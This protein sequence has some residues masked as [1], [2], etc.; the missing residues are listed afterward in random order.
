MAVIDRV[1]LKGR[2][3]VI[4]DALQKHVLEQLHINHIGM[5]KTK[6]HE[7]ESIYWPDINI[8]IEK[9]ITNYSPCLE[10]Q[11]MQLKE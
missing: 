4:P 3:I 5:A 7:Q 2:C 8:D 11:Q 1:I 10:F 6:F 9:H